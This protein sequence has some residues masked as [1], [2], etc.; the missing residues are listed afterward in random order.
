MKLIFA[1]MHDEDSRKVID[2]LNSLGYRATKLCST[3]GFLRA[4]NT[5]LM[6]GIEDEELDNVLDIIKTHSERRKQY[7][8]ASTHS[9]FNVGILTGGIEVDVG[10]STVFVIEVTQMEKY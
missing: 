7:L 3:G 6:I 9:S 1:V 2:T 10:G 5:T 8:Q 4:G